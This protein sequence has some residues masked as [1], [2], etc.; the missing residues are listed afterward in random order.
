VRGVAVLAVVGYHAVRL[1]GGTSGAHSPIIWLPAL[2]KLGVDLF[3]V[4]SGFLMLQSWESLRRRHTRGRDAVADFARRRVLRIAPV[5][6]LSIAVLVPL[7]AP[8]LLRG[9]HGL[10]QLGLLLTFQQ[11]LDPHLPGHV[12]VVY[13]SLTTEVH[14]YL[15]VPLLAAA[16]RRVGARPLL[17]GAL[18]LS[19]AWRAGL[20]SELP[21]SWIVG[22]IDE[23]VAGM[24]AAHAVA[25]SGA[26]RPGRLTAALRTRLGGITAGTFLAISALVYASRLN[27]SR[28]DRVGVLVQPLV[29]LGVAAVLT[30]ALVSGR[31]AL[32][33]SRALRA[34]GTISY[35]LYLWHYPILQRGIS[36]VTASGDASIA[37]LVVAIVVLITLAMAL[38]SVTY[39]VVEAPFVRRPPRQAVT[40]AMNSVAVR[41]SVSVATVSPTSNPWRAPATSWYSTAWDPATK[42]AW[43]AR[44]SGRN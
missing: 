43:S 22:R 38:S 15:L 26:G 31:T 23:F 12:N 30:H 4:L 28:V 6:W 10:R 32:L 9:L 20:H 21:L 5:Y 1:A 42:P 25:A 18:A 34:A 35:S 3:F 8:D 37:T 44:M 40:R 2:G 17:L 41:Q 29:G 14:F 19:L 27:G 16:L 13:W 39:R 36:A 24:V 11:Y 33:E 7:L